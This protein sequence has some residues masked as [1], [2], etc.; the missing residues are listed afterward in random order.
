MPRYPIWKTTLTEPVKGETDDERNERRKTHR[1]SLNAVREVLENEK[2][3]DDIWKEF[4]DK[5]NE[6][7]EEYIKNRKLRILKVL[8]KAGVSGKVYLAAVRE[9]TK[10]GMN[11]ILARDIDE[12]YINNYNPEWLGMQTW[13]F[14]Y[15]LISSPLSHI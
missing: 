15:V 7:K 12:I 14:S 9:Q 8:E 11:V 4:G 10:K 2:A 5:K 3:M 1:E 6:T 13:I